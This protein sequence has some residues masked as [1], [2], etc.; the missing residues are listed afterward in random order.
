MKHLVFTVTNDLTYDQRMIRICSSLANVG[1]A[2]TLVG[3]KMN[4]SVSLDKKL[5]SQKR[6]SL[7][8]QKG[9][10]FYAEYN[11][12][13]FFYL[14]FKKAD[15]ICAIDLDTIIPCL[16]ASKLKRTERVYDAHELF[17]EMQEIATRPSVY[18]VWKWIEQNT[19]PHFNFG[20]TVNKPIAEE[21]AKMYNRRYVVIRNMPVQKA[22][23]FTEKKERYIYYQGA[24]NEGRSFDTLIP[25]MKDVNAKLIIAGE[26]NYFK[27]VQELVKENKLED[28]VLLLGKIKPADLYQYA[29]AAW[30]GITFFESTGLSNYY[31]LANRYF[32][33]IQAGIPQL[34]V[35]YPVYAEI[36]KNYP[37]AV[38]IS[39][40]NSKNIA[41]ALNNLLT[42]DVLYN[43]LQQNCL[44]AREKLNW[45]EEEKFL[46]K[47]YQTIFDR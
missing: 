3:R 26:G 45:Q 28:K 20:Y 46:L 29:Q 4:D 21:F 1:Y 43:R 9:F 8:F 40:L 2:V 24:V 44:L 34:C 13:L 38:L 16:L 32:D 6:F 42:D 35:D 7:F 27:Q 31:S 22:L 18:K 33:Y 5:F 25:A 14:L 41:A 30:I 19:V 17:C 47:F 36:N 23:H 10:L 37:S 15:L 12:R 39:D 11:F